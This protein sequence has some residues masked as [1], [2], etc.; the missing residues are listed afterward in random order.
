MSS[1]K[2]AAG[3]ALLALALSACGTSS[4]PVAGTPAVSV[5]HPGRGKVDDPRTKH[6]KCLRQHHV[7]AVKVGQTVLQIGT[8]PSGPTVTFAP[9]PGAAQREQIE[10]QVEN[11]EVI[12][13]ALLVPNQASD[14]QLKVIE[15]CIAEGVTG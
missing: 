14:K 7:Q 3:G 10:G 13:S 2:L 9:T 11:A 12:G 6:L 15:D 1:A 4:K 8:P 5:Q